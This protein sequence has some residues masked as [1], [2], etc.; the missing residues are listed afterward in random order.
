[1]RTKNVINEHGGE[2]EEGAQQ[3]HEREI[4]RRTFLGYL[5]GAMS[6]FIGIV[7]GVPILGYL[8]APLGKKE[9]A[10]WITLGKVDAFK[11]PEPKLIT[12]TMTRKDGWV[13]VQEARTC[14]VVPQ[15]GGNFV[16]FNGRCTHLGCA[17]SWRTS[18]EHSGKFFCPCHD[19][20]YNREGT[21]L[22]GPPPRPLDRLEVKVQGDE[23]MVLF[24]DFRLGVPAKE[25]L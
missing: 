8:A 22:D 2:D 19:G 21:V 5:A 17:Y 6:A 25:A 13:E 15:S 3:W 10:R 9:E 18:G 1:M 20:L 14:W 23:V 16:A 7:A 12:F 4:S 11:D 24:Q